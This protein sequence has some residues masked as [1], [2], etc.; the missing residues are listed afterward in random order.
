MQQALL[1]VQHVTKVFPGIR[2]LDDVHLSLRRGEVHA[3]IGENGAGKSTLVKILTG[4]YIPTSGTM[5]FEGKEIS[6]KNAIDA[7]QAGIVAIHQEASMFPELSVTE[8]IYMGHHLRNPKTKKLDWK[9]MQE[10]TQAL[11]QRMQLDINPD[12]LVKNLSVAQRH[13]VEIVKA[14][15]L[16]ADLVIMDEP[17]SALT[18][19]EVDDLFRIVRSLKEE[20]KA[21]LFISHKFEEIFEICDYY[22]VF[23]DGQYIGEG[24]VAES[25]EDTIINMMIGRSIDQMYPH[26]EPKIGKKVLEVKHLSQLGAFKDISF[27]L[28]EGEILGLFGLVGAGRSEVVRTIFGIDK[29]SEG[30]MHLLGKPFMPKG[31]IDSMRKG[32]ALVPEDRQRQGL[33]LKMSLTHNIS[34]PVLTNLC[35]KGLVTRKKIEKS[36]VQEHGDQ[37][38]IKSAGYHVDAETLSGGNQ[39][40]VVLAKWIGTNPKILILDEPTKGID[41]ATKAAVHEFVCDMADKGVAVIL[42]SS[43]LP[44]ILGMSDR[45]VVMHE[46]YQT[47]ILDAE[48]ATAESVMRYAIATVQMEASNA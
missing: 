40:K 39:Q 21:I 29:A 15:S 18:G 32:I 26:H 6:F 37:M 36:Y 1:E 48:E 12:S 13:M 42:I 28:H 10:N 14:L 16:D 4:V 20:G 41:V 43:E 47:A 9:T 46:G 11:L 22:T 44:E 30:T 25:N 34:L 5:T 23:R 35:W 2:A 38:E 33:V 3:L 24:K 19:R 7:Q 31:A 27:D 8:N 45:I 17:T